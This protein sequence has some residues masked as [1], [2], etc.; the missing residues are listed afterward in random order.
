MAH[1]HG[2]QRS[3]NKQASGGPR[4]QR[5]AANCSRACLANALPIRCYRQR[6]APAI[7]GQD[8]IH[9]NGISDTMEGMVNE[10]MIWSEDKTR[11]RKN[12]TCCIDVALAWVADSYTNSFAN[13]LWN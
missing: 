7:K 10:E 3:T 1:A 2:V 5:S 6:S 12:R 11:I 9:G 4:R 8:E 13:L